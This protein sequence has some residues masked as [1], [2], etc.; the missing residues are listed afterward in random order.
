[1]NEFQLTG[2]I[3]VALSHFAAL[4]LAGILDEDGMGDA[5][6][7]W[8]DGSE[9]RAIVGSPYDDLE[10][11]ERVLAHA[12]RHCEPDS[13]VQR[14]IGSGARAANGLFTARAKAPALTEWSE[15]AEKRAEARPTAVTTYL[16]EQMQIALGEP[17]WWRCDK[18]ESRPDD[19]ASRWE[20]KTR[21]RGEEFLVHRLAPLARFV[22]DRTADTVVAGL[23]GALVDDEGGKN[24]PDSRT[25]TGLSRPGPVDSAVAW[26]ALWGLH[27]A[28]T[29]QRPGSPA[30]VR[31]IGQSPGTWPRNRVQPRA[32]ALPVYTEPVTARA[33]SEVFSSRYFD[34]ACDWAGAG[35]PATISARRWLREHGVRGILQLPVWVS[36]NPS[37]PERQLHA[38]TLVPL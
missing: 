11:G 37:A 25:G 33:F 34:V 35:S 29:V 13:W 22:A 36:D 10:V 19:G 2:R 31:S 3:N 17:A 38:G 4:G 23:A 1:M 12:R 6:T 15:Y 24:K 16:D 32:A 21:N 9:P 20:M 28:P 27:V 5:V 26:C 8:R 30:K 18:K 14:V 7:W